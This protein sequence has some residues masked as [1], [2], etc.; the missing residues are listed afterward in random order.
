MIQGDAAR[1]CAMFPA[2]ASAVPPGDAASAVATAGIDDMDP[3]TALN[4]FCQR[5]SRR[6]VTKN[7]IVYT[8]NKFGQQY[9]AIVTLNCVN[10]EQYAGESRSHPKD[11][12]K[13][14]AHQ[15]VLAHRE[16]LASLPPAL[17]K[18]PLRK[19]KARPTAAEQGTSGPKDGEKS[20]SETDA[21]P[22]LTPKVKLNTLCMKITHNYLKKGET[23]YECKQVIGGFQATVKLRC[24]PG[25]WSSNVWA[26]EVC[27][28]KAAAEQS[29]ANIALEQISSDASLM[30]IANQPP[31]KGKGRGLKGKLGSGKGWKAMSLYGMPF[32]G[33]GYPGKGRGGRESW[34]WGWNDVGWGMPPWS[35]PDL[36]RERIT[37]E[38]VTGEVIE[39]KD[40][41]GWIRPHEPPNHPAAQK[42]NGKLYLSRCDSV[43]SG[44]GDG[45]I[46][47]APGTL[48][49]FHIYVD[50]SGL[51]A[52]EVQVLGKA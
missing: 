1:S 33:M 18:D 2:T 46:A 27:R 16:T 44:T 29:A 32:Q 7:D 39:W 23:V 4:H 50:L 35:G 6:P 14:A 3:K 42:R 5:Y 37:T 12:E 45:P 19:K 8:L 51:G 38:A 47:L 25:E 20:G 11:A 43:Q 22:A 13:A 15:A 24:L 30:E 41:Y 21:N 28:R 52:E 31:D 9:Q 10:G 34:S 40:K 17:S 48:V 36:P 26:G 49:S